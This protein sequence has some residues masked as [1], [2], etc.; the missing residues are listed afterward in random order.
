MTTSP[1]PTEIEAKKA[2][3]RS[4]FEGLRE[5]ICAASERLEDQLPTAMPHAERPAGRFVRKP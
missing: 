1:L 4:W 3:A 2:A 5:R